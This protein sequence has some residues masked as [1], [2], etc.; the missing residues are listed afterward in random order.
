MRYHGYHG[1][2]GYDGYRGV[3]LHWPEPCS[4][5]LSSDDTWIERTED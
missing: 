2:Y 5:S 1:F 4:H 3:V